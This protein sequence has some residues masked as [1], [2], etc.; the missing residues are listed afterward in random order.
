MPPIT[1]SQM[2]LIDLVMVTAPKPAES[3]QLISPATAVLEIA[4]A[5][6]LQG[7]VRLHGLTSSPTPET[8]VRVACACAGADAK[9]G[10]S[11]PKANARKVK[12]RMK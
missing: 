2:M 7:A 12:R 1:P 4:P 3:R 11:I 9:A 10:S 6:V 5:K 8:Q